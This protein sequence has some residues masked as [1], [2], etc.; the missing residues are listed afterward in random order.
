MSGRGRVLNVGKSVA[1]VFSPRVR[2][3]LVA[4]SLML[5]VACG[6]GPLEQRDDQAQNAYDTIQSADLRPRIPNLHA[7]L[8]FLAPS[9]A[10]VV[11]RHFWSGD[12][13]QRALRRTRPSRATS[14]MAMTLDF[15]NSP[16]ADVAKVILGDIMGVGYI[17][18]PRA[19]G[20]ISL[21]SGRPI[22]KKDALFVPR[23]RSSRQQSGDD[24]RQC[25]LPHPAG[26]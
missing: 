8:T 4:S 12:P 6:G 16:I 19:Q 10:D 1:C 18:D 23:K 13:P 20:T 24:A 15:E 7:R 21:S 2:S 17:V 9:Q 11:L 14:R 22:A 3:A 26:Q 25:G 5:L